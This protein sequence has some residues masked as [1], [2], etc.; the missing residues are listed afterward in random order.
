MVNE[1]V[2]GDLKDRNRWTRDK[3]WRWP[4]P[5]QAGL[6]VGRDDQ[7]VV[8]GVR[9]GSA[10]DKAGLK[11]GDR[12]VSLGDQRILTFGDVQRVLDE[13]PLRGG[14]LP[15]SWDRGGTTHKKT[16]ELTKGWKE[17]APLVYSWRASKWPLS[18][19]PGFGG[20]L[21]SP[22]Q[23]KSQGLPEDSFAFRVNYIV[24]WPPNGST[25]RSALRAGIHKGDIIFST[26]GRSDF[27]NMNHYHAW[28]RLTRKVGETVGIELIRRGK[29]IKVTLKLVG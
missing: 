3:A 14:V 2:T 10:A 29:R 18:P 23:L 21:L 5:I 22:E 25:G 27:E 1:A 19:K 26:G 12:L 6:S 9:K 11:E 16:L 4:D 20:R 15:L 8:S 24:D 7:S 28:F 13:T 17:A